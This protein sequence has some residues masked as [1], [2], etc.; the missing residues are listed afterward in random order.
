M[1]RLKPLERCEIEMVVVIVRN[2]HEIDRRQI[3][4]TD[5][6]RD[7]AL[8][9]GSKRNGLARSDHR[10]ICQYVVAVHLDQHRGM[11][12]HGDAQSLAGNA[13]FRPGR[14]KRADDLLRPAL[15]P[16]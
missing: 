11:P 5:A 1:R 6:G 7:D 4:E 16:P 3:L 10:R 8:R 14:R 12:D 9:T 13:G 2:E 15:A